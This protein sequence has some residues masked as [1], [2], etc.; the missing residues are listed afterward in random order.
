MYA[1]VCSRQQV[2]AAPAWGNEFEEAQGTVVGALM[3]QECQCHFF[4]VRATPCPSS[5]WHWLAPQAPLAV[6]LSA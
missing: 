5:A 4:Q 1:V 2:L 3:V 6:T